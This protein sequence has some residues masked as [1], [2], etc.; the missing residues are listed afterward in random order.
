MKRDDDRHHESGG[1]D[2][3]KAAAVGLARIAEQ[4]VAAVG[5]GVQREE[6]HENAEFAPSQKVVP[7]RGIASRTPS[8]LRHPDED[9]QI[10]PEAQE[11]QHAEAHEVSSSSLSGISA[12]SQAIAL[13]TATTA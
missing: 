10:D 12:T 4:G 8:H 11:A 6:Q 3:R 5:R 2:P 1:H 9:R 7:R 13:S